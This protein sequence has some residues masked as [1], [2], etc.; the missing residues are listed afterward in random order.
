MPMRPRSAS[1]TLVTALTIP[2]NIHVS[3]DQHIISESG[4]VDFAQANC[5]AQSFHALTANGTDCL[6]AADD[7]WGHVCVNL[8]DQALVGERRMRPP[9][10][11]HQKAP[12]LAVPA[13]PQ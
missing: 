4:E 13:A 3:T 9:H 1:T 7:H 2:V 5:V 11:L 6:T 10:A 12:G 8:V